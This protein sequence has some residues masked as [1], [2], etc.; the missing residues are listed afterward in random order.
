[1]STPRFNPALLQVPLYVAGK[2]IEEV[3]EELG[4]EEVVKLASNESPLGPSPLALE[5]AR[6]A[7]REAHRY[8]GIAEIELR[9][10]LAAHLGHDLQADHILTG[11]GGTDVL[12]MIVQAFV[13][14]GGNTVMSRVTFPMYRIYTT[15]FGGTPLEVDTTPQYRQDL[16]QMSELVNEDT[17]L[18]FLCSPNNPTGEIISQAEAD[19][20]LAR[21]PGHVIVVF[22]EAYGAFVRET[23]CVNSLEYVRQGKNVIVLHSFSKSTGLAG[24]RVGYLVAPLEIANY[25]RHAQ[26]PFQ[27]GQ[28]ALRAAAA[29]LDDREYI[30]ANQRMVWEGREYLYAELQRLNLTCLPSQANFLVLL[31]PPL[32]VAEFV[33]ALAR[34]GFIIR[35]MGGFGLPDGVRVTV[36]R[37]EENQAFIRALETILAAASTATASA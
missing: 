33:S 31:N 15:M 9:R 2:S 12:R 16:K 25:L 26:I 10:K 23:T 28:I 29:S 3:Q 24:L 35:P 13:F 11:N 1:M 37:P 14:D 7:L 27:T 8:P 19:A 6:S 32:P 18:V 21:I 22:D 34:A 20:F 5:A 4:L 30:E 17:R 36:G